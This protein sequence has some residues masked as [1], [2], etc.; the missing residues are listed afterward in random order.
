L[1]PDDVDLNN[2]TGV[3]L[4]VPESTD[5]ILYSGETVSFDNT[6]ETK[7]EQIDTEVVAE[8]SKI[9]KIPTMMDVLIYLMDHYQ[10]PLSVEKNILIYKKVKS[11]TKIDGI[12]KTTNFSGKRKIIYAP[13]FCPAGKLKYLKDSGYNAVM[14]RI[15][16]KTD[17]ARLSKYLDNCKS[18]DIHVFIDTTMIMKKFS[19]GT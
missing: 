10:I 17:F 11:Y 15:F 1:D 7:T 4:F 9:A 8:K 13:Y 12:Y 18:Y 16:P 3:N 6:N 19:T 5:V 14:Y 2:E